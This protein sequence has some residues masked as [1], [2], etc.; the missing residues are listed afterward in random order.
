VWSAAQRLR[1]V[2]RGSATLFHD[3]IDPH[4]RKVVVL[5]FGDHDPSGLDMT[6]DIRDRLALFGAPRVDVRRLALN[7]NQVEEYEPPPN[8][9]KETDSRFA[10]YQAEHGDESWELDALEPSTLATLVRDEVNDL[11]DRDEWNDWK[12]REKR[13]KAELQSISNQ[14]DDVVGHFAA[15]VEEEIEDQ[16]DDEEGSED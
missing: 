8:P 16:D 6:R 12:R 3:P 9:A 7:M 1:S 5:H 14:Y 15:D 13:T 10:N 4:P 11:I 2:Q